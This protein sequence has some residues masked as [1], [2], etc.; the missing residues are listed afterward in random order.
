MIDIGPSCGKFARAA[1][2]PPKQVNAAGRTDSC[3][4]IPLYRHAALHTVL[5]SVHLTCSKTKAMLRRFLSQSVCACVCV[6]IYGWVYVMPRRG[7]SGLSG[8]H[9]GP[10]NARSCRTAILNTARTLTFS[11]EILPRPTGKRS[12]LLRRDKGGEDARTRRS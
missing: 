1:L 5:S 7:R 10:G 2:S 4:I 9:C 12:Y 8:P 3:L 11:R 6:C